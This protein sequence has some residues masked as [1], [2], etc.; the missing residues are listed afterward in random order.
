MIAILVEIAM[1]VRLKAMKAQE[2][3]GIADADRSKI[4]QAK[5]TSRSSLILPAQKIRKQVT[6]PVKCTEKSSIDDSKI[7]A[8]PEGL[9]L[10]PGAGAH[11]NTRMELAQ[12]EAKLNNT[13]EKVKSLEEKMS[14]V[15]QERSAIEIKFYQKDKELEKVTVERDDLQYSIDILQLRSSRNEQK[16][17]ANKMTFEKQ[18]MHNEEIIRR[19]KEEREEAKAAVQLYDENYQNLQGKVDSYDDE[20][21]KSQA[22]INKLKA[23]LAELDKRLAEQENKQHICTLCRC[24]GIVTIRCTGLVAILVAMCIALGTVVV[25][26]HRCE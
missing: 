2:G 26:P 18:I 5:D 7:L 14:E 6:K 12:Q 17:Y 22:M 1:S 3:Q 24:Q 16:Q 15:K 13:L 8:T 21:K 10:D 11:Y 23:D 20:V 25:L 9:H 19:L 4:A